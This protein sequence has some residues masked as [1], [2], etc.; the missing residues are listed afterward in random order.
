MYWL[1]NVLKIQTNFE[2]PT[3]FKKMAI[4]SSIA[5]FFEPPNFFCYYLR[6][7]ILKEL[8]IVKIVHPDGSK[9]R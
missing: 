3:I 7:L 8:T 5:R 1:P 4:S 9:A 6:K 2:L